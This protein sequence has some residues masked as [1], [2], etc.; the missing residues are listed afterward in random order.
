M[1]KRSHRK[2][3]ARPGERQQWKAKKRALTKRKTKRPCG[4]CLAC[5]TG[6]RTLCEVPGHPI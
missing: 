2:H 6:Y 5:R 4:E 3:R 1:K